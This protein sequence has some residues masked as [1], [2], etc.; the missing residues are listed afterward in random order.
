MSSGTRSGGFNELFDMQD[1][2]ERA[3]GVKVDLGNR[4][5]LHP[6]LRAEIEQ[7]AIRIF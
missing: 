5:G 1:V 2:L 7:S 3:L 4:T 6:V